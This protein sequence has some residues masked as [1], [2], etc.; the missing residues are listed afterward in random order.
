M[1][2]DV[3]GSVIFFLLRLWW[4]AVKFCIKNFPAAI[5]VA[6]VFLLLENV[7]NIPLSKSYWGVVVFIVAL[8]AGFV[9][10]ALLV[11]K[12]PFIASLMSVLHGK[13]IGVAKNVRKGARVGN[14]AEL[15][16]Y[17]T[18]E[19]TDGLLL[20]RGIQEEK[21]KN[22]LPPLVLPWGRVFDHGVCVGTT[23]AGKTQIFAPLTD[24]M[25]AVE[26]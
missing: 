21:K 10:Q 24:S 8:F 19:G 20:G 4:G 26:N 5:F 23:G 11:D 18:K 3:A 22:S 9:V 1:S 2:Q 13:D 15:A 16:S 12:F 14:A 17:L 7:L 6:L 25:M